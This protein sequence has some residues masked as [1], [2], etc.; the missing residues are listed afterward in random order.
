[1]GVQNSST[2]SYPGYQYVLS[3]TM[4]QKHVIDQSHLSPY[5]PS[6]V[7]RCDRRRPESSIFWGV[8][9][10]CGGVTAGIDSTEVLS[11]NVTEILG[12]GNAAGATASIS[13]PSSSTDKL[14]GA[15]FTAV[16]PI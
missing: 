5:P 14:D 11:A 7:L 13:P 1:M 16:A 12:A 6:L 10:S 9:A 3:P 8:G 2:R 15:R 4:M